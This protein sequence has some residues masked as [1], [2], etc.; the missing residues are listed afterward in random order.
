MNIKEINEEMHLKFKEFGIKR[1]NISVERNYWLVRTS[2]GVWY[3]EFSND[4]FIGINWNE[5]TEKHCKTDNRTEAEV[6]ISNNYPESKQPGKIIKN[7]I[8]F[9]Q[10][11]KIGDVVMIPDENSKKINFGIISGEDVYEITVSQTKI[12]E[13][14][15]PFKKRRKVSWKKEVY[16]NDFSL[17]L[18]RMMQS[19]NTISNAN[20]YADEIDSILN[21]FYLKGDSIHYKIRVDKEKDLTSKALRDLVNIPWNLAD[22]INSDYNLNE[23]TTTISVQSPGDQKLIGKG[24]KAVSYFVG[25]LTLLSFST[26]VV[27]GGKVTL[28]H[29]GISFESPGLLKQFLKD[30]NTKKEDFTRKLEEIEKLKKDNNIKTPEV[31]KYIEV[32]EK[33]ETEETKEITDENNKTT[34]I[35]KKTTSSR[36]KKLS[37]E[38]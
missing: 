12:D 5:L 25:L 9:Y 26:V 27:I 29:N 33:T 18:F 19:H 36:T 8:K 37:D 14:Y 11:I 2:G 7:I 15:C 6:I 34:K 28:N 21:D 23:L 10:E 3:D 30:D 20:D 32:E 1:P 17:K 13:G 16:R 24:P 22:Y 38:N 31:K 4:N 35:H